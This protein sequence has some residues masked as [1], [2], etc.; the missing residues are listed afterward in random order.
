MG[1]FVLRVLSW[2]HVGLETITLISNA[3]RFERWVRNQD[4]VELRF[5]VEERKNHL[6]F[7]TV[8]SCLETITSNSYPF[9]LERL[10]QNQEKVEI[11]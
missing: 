1:D 9:R 10:V 4:E 3:F 5:L 11:L 6:F 8:T 2:R 7:Q